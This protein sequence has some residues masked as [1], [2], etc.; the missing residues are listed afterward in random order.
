MCL[1]RTN[2]NKDEFHTSY[3]DYCSEGD[4]LYFVPFQVVGYYMYWNKD[5]FQAAGLNPETPPST[6]EEWQ[7]YA[8]KITDEGQEYLW[9]WLFLMIIHIRLHI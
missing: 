7:S 9:L 2:L 1:I 3:L 6:W 5:L 8:E 4:K